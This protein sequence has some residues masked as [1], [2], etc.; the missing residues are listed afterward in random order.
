[1]FRKCPIYK[2]FRGFS[3]KRKR[4]KKGKEIIKKTENN[5]IRIIIQ[6]YIITEWLLCQEKY[7]GYFIKLNPAD[8][9]G[10]HQL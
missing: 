9:C 8:A 4:V 3:L 7:F 5:K 10:S 6:I 1:M 2:G